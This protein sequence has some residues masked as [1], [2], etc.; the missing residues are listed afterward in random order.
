LEAD[1]R[2]HRLLNRKRSAG[3]GL[4]EI[5]VALLIGMFGVMVMMQVLSLSEGQKRTTTGGND[6]MNEGVMALYTMQSDIRMGGFG[7]ADIRLLGCNLQRS[8]VTFALLAPV[9]IFPAGN[10]FPAYFPMPD[11]NTDG[12]L[13]L[14][15]T[16]NGS[17]QGDALV[18]GSGA[19]GVPSTPWMFGVGD[20]VVVAPGTRPSPCNVGLDQ[21]AT[22]A[23]SPSNL[24]LTSGTALPLTSPVTSTLFNLGRS[25]RAVGYAVRNGNLTTCDFSI[26]ATN[27]TGSAN[28]T[29]IADNI[30][31]LRAQYG[32]DA[33]ATGAMDGIIDLY[34]QTTPSAAA[35]L[36][37]DW[38]KISGIR[39]ALVARSA[40]SE[41]D[42]VTTAA[43]VWDGGVANNP[44][45]SVNPI[46]LTG[47]ATWQN[48]RYKLFQTTVPL[49]NISWM[50]KVI[51][52]AGTS[53]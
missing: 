41:K 47:N 28:W 13:V 49:R 52:A 8:G 29:S 16:T 42:L 40:Q 44:A 39:V 46:D 1:V 7:I 27:C 23:T 32:R 45:G 19:N 3:F 10:P 18:S 9:T 12:L 25:I 34:D 5:M 15:A 35:T 20:I 36:A 37:C 31:S 6:A 21:V 17:T 43:P 51:S 33:A 38:A 24:T 50:G 53:C 48:Y 2:N 30:V 26:S 4:V 22:V 14:Y 11:P